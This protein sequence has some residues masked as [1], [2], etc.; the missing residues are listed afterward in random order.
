MNWLKE[1]W[2]KVGLLVILTMTVVGVFYW[3]SYRPEQIKKECSW[4]EKHTDEILELTQAQANQAKIDSSRCYSELNKINSE[5]VT[6][7]LNF[8]A[9][10][11]QLECA[12]L[13]SIA[14]TRPHPAVPSKVYYA[15][16]SPTEYNFCLHSRGL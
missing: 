9:M 6:G 10:N 14:E 3:Y 13:S 4:V 12:R 7:S 15:Q 16:A 2:F 1:N 5:K 8:A 11:K